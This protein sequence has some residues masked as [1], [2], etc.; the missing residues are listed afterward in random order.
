MTIIG[1]LPLLI[2][3]LGHN[4]S[5]FS[6]FGAFGCLLDTFDPPQSHIFRHVALLLKYRK[7]N[8]NF[9][10]K[11]HVFQ[12]TLLTHGCSWPWYVS[13]HLHRCLDQK[14]ITQTPYCW[15]HASGKQ[16]KTWPK[17]TQNWIVRGVKLTPRPIGGEWNLT[18]GVWCNILW[19]RVPM[20]A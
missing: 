15:H 7:S 16:Q 2:V 18:M 11:N 14:S 17:W 12:C 6:E 4:F 5:R 13:C 3:Q 19:P 8:W 1:P 9:G 10:G 20:A